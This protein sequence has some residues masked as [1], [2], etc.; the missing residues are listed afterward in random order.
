MLRK[1]LH[2]SKDGRFTGAASTTFN[3]CNN[4]VV[5][6]ILF[7]SACSLSKNRI[8][9]RILLFLKTLFSQADDD[10][11]WVGVYDSPFKA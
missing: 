9:P 8:L 10:G 11:C 7:G 1:P 4:I 3:G 2:V 6:K 5:L